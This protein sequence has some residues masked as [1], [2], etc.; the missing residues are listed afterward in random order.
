MDGT[1]KND[2]TVTIRVSLIGLVLLAFCRA[3][4]AAPT[5]VDNVPQPAR[6]GPAA[7]SV[8]G[9]IM[10][11]NES[12]GT[13]PAAG[14]DVSLYEV[15]TAQTRTTRADNDGGFE[16]RG[17]HLG[18]LYYV[19]AVSQ[20]RVPFGSHYETRPVYDIYLQAWIPQQ[21]LV[22]DE[23]ASLLSWHQ[24]VNV[25]Q[26]GAYAIELSRHNADPR[27][28]AAL[29]PTWSAGSSGPFPSW[30]TAVLKPL[31]AAPTP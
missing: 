8:I 2:R 29:A 26:P 15:R 14:L 16:F 31:G 20:Y 5:S 24:L 18:D 27:F 21:V 12:G 3:G 17:L 23:F 11:V 19:V 28:S 25:S 13:V 22:P 6:P 1:A 30:R 4:S 7:A 9:R 10:R